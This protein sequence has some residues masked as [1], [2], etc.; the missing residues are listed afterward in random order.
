MSEKRKRK[1]T[2]DSEFGVSR[3]VDFKG[4]KY[5][6]NRTQASIDATETNTSHR[7]VINFDF[8]PSAS[9]YIH[10]I[11]RTARGGDGALPRIGHYFPFKVFTMCSWHGAIVCDP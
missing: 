10:R 4:V 6:S 3:G 8:P 7:A 9:S 2:K 5:V 11:G 1:A